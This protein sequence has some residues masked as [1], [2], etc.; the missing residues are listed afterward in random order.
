M[1]KKPC[2]ECPFNK[3]AGLTI[4]EL[5]GSP[6]ETY[7]GQ[8]NGPFWLP[9]HMEKGYAGKESSPD[10]VGICVGAAMLRSKLPIKDKFNS[11]LTPI[12]EDT[13]NDSFASCADFMAH[14]KDIPLELAEMMTQEKHIQAMVML[15]YSK[16]MYEGKVWKN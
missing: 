3:K 4:S 5:G 8:L 9:C 1:K 6:P 2:K 7:I 16:L 15:E 10:D 12:I 11:P 13:N 14:Y